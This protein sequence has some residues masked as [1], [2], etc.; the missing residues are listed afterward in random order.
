MNHIPALGSKLY[1]W[2]TL[3]WFVTVETDCNARNALFTYVIP[4]TVRSSA[5]EL[6]EIANITVAGIWGLDENKCLFLSMRFTA[7]RNA[8]GSFLR[9][10]QYLN[11]VTRLI[12]EGMKGYSPAMNASHCIW[13]WLVISGFII[14]IRAA[15]GSDWAG[16]SGGFH[17]GWG[18][19]MHIIESLYPRI[20]ILGSSGI[21]G[22]VYM[23]LGTCL[24]YVYLTL[25]SLKNVEDSSASRHSWPFPYSKRLPAIPKACPW[26]WDRGR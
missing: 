15:H 5:I 21:S 7:T 9:S 14:I 4:D 3:T 8:F 17:P 1:H 11:G 16:W 2:H 25:P 22:I 12:D 24:F 20:E 26:W 13:K 18:I 23:A 19:G 6:G 10:I